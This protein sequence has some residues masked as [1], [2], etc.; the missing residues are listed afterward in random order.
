SICA[1]APE[2]VGIQHNINSQP[3]NTILGKEFRLLYGSERIQETVC[4]NTFAVSA[5]S[6][7]QVNPV[8]TEQLYQTALSYCALTG[9]EFVMDAY[10]GIGTIS[11]LLARHAKE[12]LGIELFSQAVEDAVHNAKANSINNAEF[13]CAPAEEALPRCIEQG[14]KPDVIVADPPRKGCERPFLDAVIKSGVSR[15]VYISC[16]PGTLARDCGILRENGYQLLCVQPVDMFPQ[17][18]GVENV[19][20]L[21]H[22]K[23]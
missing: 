2:T 15:M 1:A 18:A 9:N 12:V 6:F 19:A 23:C 14:M 11:L 4:G 10:C 13:L 20:L 5:A 17:T 16:D 3:D 8:Q 7:L 21:E 22:N